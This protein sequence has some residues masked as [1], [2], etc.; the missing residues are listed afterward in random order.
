MGFKKC[1]CPT[2][3]GFFWWGDWGREGR[4]G[5]CGHTHAKFSVILVVKKTGSCLEAGHYLTNRLPDS[6]TVCA[7]A[8]LTTKG[9]NFPCDAMAESASL[10]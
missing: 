4:K 2:Q 5:V 3:T 1:F 7:A 10:V 9:L 8:F 6:R